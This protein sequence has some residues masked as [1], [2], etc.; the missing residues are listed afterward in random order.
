LISDVLRLPDGW[1]RPALTEDERRPQSVRPRWVRLVEGALAAAPRFGSTDPVAEGSAPETHLVPPLTPFLDAA[2]ALLEELTRGCTDVDVV[3]RAAVNHCVRQTL[4]QHL[5]RIAAPVLVEELQRLR[6]TGSLE[7]TGSQERFVDFLRQVGCQD[8]LAALMI[9]YPVLARL[10]G[11]ACVHTA[12]AVDELLRRFLDDRPDL[13][14]GVLD[15]DPGRLVALSMNAGDRHQGG[16][17]VAVL[18]F[19]DNSRVVYK[20][21]PLGL[22]AR[23]GELLAWFAA[24]WP[25]VAPLG[26]RVLNRGVYG[27]TGF[28]QRRPCRSASEVEVFYRRLGALLAL[29]YVLDGTDMHCENIVANGDHPVL[30][31]VETL[32][33]PTWVPRS[34][35]GVD[36]ALAWLGESVARAAIL[37]TQL[38]DD[39]GLVDM[40]GLGG[41][42][43]VPL[44]GLV[45]VLEA[46]GTDK[47]HLVRGRAWCGDVSNRPRLGDAVV[48]PLDHVP[49]LLSGFRIGYDAL[50]TAAPQLLAADGPLAGWA[51]EQLRIVARHTYIYGYLLADALHPDRLGDAPA[52]A[53]FLA[54]LADDSSHDHL[55]LLAEHELS[56]L[57]GNDIPVFTARVGSR[58]VRTGSG[59]LLNDFL[60]RTGLDALREKLFRLG[61]ADRRE[62]EWLIEA[63]LATRRPWVGHGDPLPLSSPSTAVPVDRG[64]VLSVV[65]ELGDELVAWSRQAGERANWVGLE[66]V[67]D[68]VWSVL[69]MGAGLAD[70]YCGTALFLAE[71]AA[72]SGIGRYAEVAHRAVQGLPPLLRSLA[73]EPGLVQHVGSGGFFGFGGIAYAI[74]RL[75]VLLEDEAL[76]G[77]LP[78]AVHLVGIADRAGLCSVAEGTAG[79]VAALLSVHAECGLPAAAELARQLGPRLTDPQTLTGDGFLRGRLGA[80]WARK[81]FMRALGESPGTVADVPLRIGVQSDDDAVST[82]K[83]TAGQ[84]IG[85]CSGAA[86][87]VL[88][89]VDLGAVDRTS[90]TATSFVAAVQRRP[91]SSDHSLCHGEAGVL[92]AL[93]GLAGAGNQ[94]AARAVVH[95]CARLLADIHRH[96]PRC[97][98]PGGIFSPGLLTGTAGIGYGLLR[99]A[100]GDQ[101]PSVLLLRPG[102]EPGP[103]SSSD[104]G[105]CFPEGERG[106]HP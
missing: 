26:L 54:Q 90:A 19:A 18:T 76:A 34:V 24:R 23:F 72:L 55:T 100:F 59:T 81:R 31:D 41:E 7:G 52:R 20:P 67:N 29:L 58:H 75:S 91:V 33:H 21:R 38:L 14:G 17:S 61:A 6:E 12:E 101:V 106:R 13:I 50:M 79:A 1:W 104:G 86:G 95:R 69:P 3:D 99:A 42:A 82:P 57:H 73:Q 49:A 39:E 92:E 37:P 10:I 68:R 87:R 70:G 62:Q 5:A 64:S 40:S 60:P 48:D 44:P 89:G 85:W 74:A 96:G 56:E 11:E 93:A 84:G 105:V 4:G 102:A 36:P 15:A 80:E 97:A 78:D 16:R 94:Q 51:E 25:E 103:T 2:Q 47:M 98:T 77:C 43:G 22:L 8:L 32:L 63:T 65:C 28:V 45:D 46:A 35:S 53:R 66:L 30:V 27:W 83:T 71:L 9:R 88:A